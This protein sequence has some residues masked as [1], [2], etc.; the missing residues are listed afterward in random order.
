MAILVGRIEM[1]KK[2]PMEPNRRDFLM[3]GTAGFAA[4]LVGGSAPL[5]AARGK[6][7][8]GLQLYSVRQDCARD[9]PGTL[10]AVAKMGYEGVE[11]AGYFER[12][13]RELRR[14]LDGNGLK[15]CGTHTAI[16][17]LLGD[18]LKETI[19]FNRILGNRFLIVPSLGKNK[20]KQDWLNS[21]RLFNEL[22]HK[23]K[24]QGLLVGYHNH[25]VEFQPLEG[26]LPWD[27]FFGNTNKSVIMQFD[28]GNGMVGG[29]DPLV[30]LRKYP[31]R[32]VTVHVK[33]FS[34]SNRDALVGEGDVNWKQVFEEVERQGV[35]EWYIVEYERAAHSPLRSVELCLLN[36]RKMGK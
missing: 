29:A 33:E 36:L 16:D 21:A 18:K 31:G 35:T 12:T 25:T 22:S 30:F 23:V 4:I 14:L 2:G 32:A 17:T 11:F 5:C 10:A 24:E 7:P 19:E 9:L 20:T 34:K 15:C 26:E 8:I 1:H 3:K 13:A 27:S 6:I 28:V